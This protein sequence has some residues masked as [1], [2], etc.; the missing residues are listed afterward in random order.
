MKTDRLT[1]LVRAFVCASLI[2]LPCGC[3]SLSGGAGD[4]AVGHR[5]L[6]SGESVSVWREGNSG[7]L[8]YVRE[9]K[10]YWPGQ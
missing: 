2:A 9:G 10:Q 6:P 8:Y 4:R 1:A 5:T 3:E 7:R